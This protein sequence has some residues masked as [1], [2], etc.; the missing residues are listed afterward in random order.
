MIVWSLDNRFVL[1][2][3]MGKYYL[4]IFPCAISYY[5][6]DND[7]NIYVVPDCLDA[8]SHHPERSFMANRKLLF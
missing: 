8:L 1:A 5:Q 3:I 7:V 6:L 4:Q 2:A